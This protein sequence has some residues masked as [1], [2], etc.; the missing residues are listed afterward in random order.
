MFESEPRPQNGGQCPL[1]VDGL[2]SHTAINLRWHCKQNKM[3]L[4]F[5]P[6]HTSHVLQFLDLGVFAPLK[7]RYRSEIAALA[8]LDDASPVKKQR[9]ITCYNSA[10]KETLTPCLL[11]IRWQAAGI[12]SYNPVKG[13]NSSQVQGSK[14]RQVTPSQR[15]ETP[16]TLAHQRTHDK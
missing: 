1:I 9:F 15:R 5:L 10:R 6:A 2:G 3:H 7:S 14:P 11:R 16:P 4:L 12:Y 8:S 13:I